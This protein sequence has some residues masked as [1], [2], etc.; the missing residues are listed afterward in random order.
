MLDCSEVKAILCKSF[1]KLLLHLVDVWK[2]LRFKKPAVSC[3]NMKVLL[4][5]DSCDIC[6]IY[7]SRPQ[8]I[9]ER[10]RHNIQFSA[11]FRLSY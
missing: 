9:L 5:T 8:E 7:K 1:V 6:F 4:S 2:I 10:V 11:I 3:H